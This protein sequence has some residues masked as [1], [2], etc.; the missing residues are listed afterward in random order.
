MPR[1]GRLPAEEK[2][3]LVEQ[4]LAGE[5]GTGEI[6]QK[7]NI[8]GQL[9]YDWVR[10]YKVR[11]TEGLCRT[12]GYRKYN[13]ELK[14]QAVTE[15][16]S[17]TASLREIC[18]KYDITDKGMLQRWIKCY[19]GH[20]DTKQPSIRGGIYMTKG[21][22][23]T[24]DERIEIVSHCIAN[25]KDYGKTIEQYGISYNQ[26]YEWVRKY[27]KG[28]V[29][30]L[31]DQRGKRKNEASMSEIE[32]LRARLKLK[33][34]ENLRLVMENELLKKLAVLERGQDEG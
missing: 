26:I 24:L 6:K 12:D 13:P 3:R 29:D 23:T 22:K 18:T 16:L 10:I 2:I 25:N 33:E 11:G 8:N 17:G 27:E 7:Y 20:E 5:I 34:S 31:I 14:Q 32:K 28:G 9:F 19:N 4:Y 21:R 15:Y 30:R 1:K